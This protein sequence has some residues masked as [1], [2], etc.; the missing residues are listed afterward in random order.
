MNG[1]SQSDKSSM[2]AAPPYTVADYTLKLWMSCAEALFLCQNEY[3]HDFVL[4]SVY[5][6][7]WHCRLW[8]LQI[9]DVLPPGSSFYVNIVF[10]SLIAIIVLVFLLL[11][12]FKTNKK[13]SSGYS[14]SA[15][16]GLTVVMRRLQS[17][18]SVG[19]SAIVFPSYYLKHSLHW[20]GGG[21]LNHFS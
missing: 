21:P 12:L 11:L 5:G 20:Q 9:S 4:L 6:N 7:Y 19:Q 1:T 8:Y 3:K 2:L 15:N 18:L 14:F 10:S 16:Q 17:L 13:V